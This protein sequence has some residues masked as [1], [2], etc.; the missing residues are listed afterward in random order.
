MGVDVT[1][2]GG[3]GATVQPAVY[4]L[5]ADGSPG[6]LLIAGPVLAAAAV[7]TPSGAVAGVVP[8][9]WSWVAML[10][11][12]ATAPAPNFLCV[13][14]LPGAMFGSP[15]ATPTAGQDLCYP[16][17]SGLAALPAVFASSGGASVGPAVWVLT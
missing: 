8:A 11:L 3:A 10:T 4:G 13:T 14:D 17:A 16:F 6:A 1:V 12:A 5:A 15:V 7:G 9:G 2:A